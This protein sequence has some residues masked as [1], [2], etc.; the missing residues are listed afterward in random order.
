LKSQPLKLPREHFTNAR[1]ITKKHRRLFGIKKITGGIVSV[2]VKMAIISSCIWNFMVFRLK[3][4][5]KNLSTCH[6]D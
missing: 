6:K 2:A 5:A 1:Y 3:K 4:R